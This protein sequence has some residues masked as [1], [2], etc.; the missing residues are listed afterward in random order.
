M[1]IKKKLLTLI[2]VI[3]IAAATIAAVLPA[4]NACT[5]C[6]QCCPD[7]EACCPSVCK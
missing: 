6:D 7:P 2:G 3:G 4:K 5:P 1:T